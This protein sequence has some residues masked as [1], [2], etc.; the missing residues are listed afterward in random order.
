M[1]IKRC[2]NIIKL[3]KNHLR[4]VFHK[5]LSLESQRYIARFGYY[6]DYDLNSNK[7]VEILIRAE[8]KNMTDFITAFN[9]Y[10]SQVSNI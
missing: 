10:L 9:D 6:Y 8:K 5:G 1:K 4:E 2:N 3:C 7:M